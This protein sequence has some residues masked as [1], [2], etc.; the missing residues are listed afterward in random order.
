MRYPRWLLDG[1]YRA[2]NRICVPLML[3]E[4]PGCCFPN[5]SPS[6]VQQHTLV[7]WM[8]WEKN[9]PLWQH[10]SKLGK[11]GEVKHSLRHSYLLCGRNHWLRQ[12]LL[13]LRCAALGEGRGGQ[14]K[15]ISLLSSLHLISFFSPPTVCWNFSGL[16]DKIVLSVSDYQN[17]CFFE[18]K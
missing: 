7:F 2:G 16:L 9:G 1:V 15:T 11:A 3:P 12:S 10:L 6:L 18:K 14:S 8:G 5:V 17:Q 4:S 13:A